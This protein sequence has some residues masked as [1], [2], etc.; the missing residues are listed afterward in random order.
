MLRNMRR[1]PVH[2][3]AYRAGMWVG[4]S[5]DTLVP[6]DLISLTHF[7]QKKGIASGTSMNIFCVIISK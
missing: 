5:S 6:G 7:A 3:Y 2:I 4:I 1:P